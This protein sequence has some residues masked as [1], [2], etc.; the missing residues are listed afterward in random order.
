M[1]WLSTHLGMLRTLSNVT[2][3]CWLLNNM[4]NVHTHFFHYNHTV[5]CLD[6]LRQALASDTESFDDYRRRLH[7]L[8]SKCFVSRQGTLFCACGMTRARR[9][10]MKGRPTKGRRRPSSVLVLSNV[11]YKLCITRQSTIRNSL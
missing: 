3:Y 2:N 6:K 10:V 1:K 11:N 4:G 8:L 7:F 9:T 5:Q